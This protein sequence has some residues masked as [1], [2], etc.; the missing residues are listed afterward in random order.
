[1]TSD[2]CRAEV[3][4]QELLRLDQLRDSAATEP[5]D[6]P[7]LSRELLAR[8]PDVASRAQIYYRT[9]MVLQS[10]GMTEPAAAADAGKQALAL[11][12]A[13]G[14]KMQLHIIWA[15]AI[16]TAHGFARGQAILQARGDSAREYLLAIKVAVD[17]NVPKVAP[18]RPEIPLPM[19]DI[20]FAKDE[21]PAKVAAYQAEVKECEA[22]ISKAWAEW[23]H[24]EEQED[25][26]IKRDAAG[27]IVDLYT[28]FPFAT[29]ELKTVATEVL[30]N[31]PIVTELVDRVETRIASDRR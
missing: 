7:A 28:K 20:H 30:G 16:V 31:N 26:V 29:A 9:A 18:P 13:P 21:E 6:I 27:G 22:E 1:M 23:R 12:Q 2:A 25:M 3:S 14:R 11:P 19:V 4:H 5:G 15:D 10:R 8:Y 17:N 24:V